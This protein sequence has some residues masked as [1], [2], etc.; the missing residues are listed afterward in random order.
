MEI[1]AVL[2]RGSSLVK[3]LEHYEKI[4][5]IYLVNDFNDELLELGLDKFKH[6]K[7]VH[8]VG[9][10]PNQLSKK[11]YK[12]LCINKVICNAFDSSS[13]QG[14]YPVKIKYLDEKMR[15]RGY[16]SVGMEMVQSCM[17]KFDTYKE[18]IK[19]LKK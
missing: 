1:C 13:F 11:A 9:R 6:K 12:K 18:L 4:P 7:I 15:K 16:P 8:V 19:F 14:N 10:G 3:Y 2:G 17:D 5:K